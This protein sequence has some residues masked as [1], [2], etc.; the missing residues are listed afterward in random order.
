MYKFR[1]ELM[2]SYKKT[3]KNRY[4]KGKIT[5]DD[6]RIFTIA[7]EGDEKT[8]IFTTQSTRR[9]NKGESNDRSMAA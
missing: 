3:L 6:G 4:R 9:E 8:G 2:Q 7:M 1:F 5:R